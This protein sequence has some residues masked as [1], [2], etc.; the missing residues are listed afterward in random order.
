M[1]LTLPGMVFIYN[2]EEIGMHN[3]EIPPEL[4]QDPQAVRDPHNPAGRDIARTPMQWTL[5]KNAGFTTGNSTWLPISPDADTRNVETESSDPD[6]FLSLYR[7]LG[8]LRTKTPAIRTG[9]LKTVK[10]YHKDILG[11]IR[12]ND[13]EAYLVLVNFGP[14]ENTCHLL[15]APRK[16]VVSS[17]TGRSVAA[18]SGEEITLAAHEAVVFSV[19]PTHHTL[20]P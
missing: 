20:W 13:D 19:D 1:L 15:E 2:G 18:E 3:V 8:E 11:Y 17:A 10:T 14:R 5:G 4:V 12:Y 16:R 7:L 9:K 6:S